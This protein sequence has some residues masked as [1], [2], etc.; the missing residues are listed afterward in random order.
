[1]GL[2]H[3]QRLQRV[4]GGG[5]MERTSLNWI[6]RVQL[7]VLGAHKDKEVIRAIKQ[8]RRQR[9]CLLSAYECYIVHSLALAQS[10]QPG[11]LAEVGTYQGGSARLIC[12]AK[13]DRTF[14][15]FDTFEGLPQATGADGKV[16]STKQYDS[17]FESVREYLREFPNVHL[18]KGRFPETA[19]P[20]EDRTFSFAHFDVDLYESTL[21][22]LE[23]FY[24]R[25]IVGGVMLSHDYS[26]LAGVRKAFEEFLADKPEALIEL[27]STQCMVIKLPG[28][29]A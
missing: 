7:R 18:Y 25:M 22:C 29:Q 21:A 26:I 11:E 12:E 8:M 1:M 27:P 6:S 24:P 10:Q 28:P 3:N 23:F 4:I 20:I 14:H 19:G 9:R 2:A 15:V 17:S 13:G 16:H 5:W